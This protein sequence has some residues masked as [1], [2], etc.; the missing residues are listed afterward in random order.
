[1]TF[2]ILITNGNCYGKKTNYLTTYQNPER[3]MYMWRSVNN[4]C[5]SCKTGALW[6]LVKGY[7]TRILATF[8]LLLQYSKTLLDWSMDV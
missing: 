8:D 1:M 4:V 6:K 2:P 5:N 7:G 3:S